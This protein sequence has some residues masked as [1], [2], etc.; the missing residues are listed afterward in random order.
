M[1][2]LLVYK[3]IAEMLSTLWYLSNECPT[4]ALRAAQKTT[5][6]KIH[7]VLNNFILSLQHRTKLST[8]RC[9]AHILGVGDH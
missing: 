4:T 3:K 8:A 5:E 7:V 9:V 6:N 1:N 2:S